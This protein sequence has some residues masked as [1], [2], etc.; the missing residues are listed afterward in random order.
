MKNGVFMLLGLW[1]VKDL[2]FSL[3]LSP[4]RLTELLRSRSYCASLV[5]SF[6]NLYRI[7]SDIKYRIMSI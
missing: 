1:E 3:T 6:P 2:F 7:P 5:L 4:E